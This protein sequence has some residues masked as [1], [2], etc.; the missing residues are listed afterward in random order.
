[1]N[2]ASLVSNREIGSAI[3]RRRNELSLSL[4]QLGSML[5]VSAQQ[6]QRYEN[7]IDRLNVER[8]QEIA[9]ALSVPV[10][11]FFLQGAHAAATPRDCY[12]L[13]AYFGSIQSQ[14]V[15]SIMLEWLRVLAQNEGKRSVPA[16]KLGR[17]T[18]KSPILL[19][20]DDEQVLSIVRLFLENEGYRNLH[21]I[22]DSRS[23]IPFLTEKAISLIVLDLL[24]PHMTGN[25]LLLT[26]R[27]SFP[28]IPVIIL[29]AM[30]DAESAEYCMKS[31][32]FDYLVKP[33]TPDR[34]LSA[35]D[36]ALCSICS[37]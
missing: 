17:Y 5:N 9:R 16:L 20:D 8:L 34:F 35:I 14:E 19:V 2:Q 30:G 26:L 33:V 3:R 32:V 24:M 37:E 22:R 10:C 27:E 31:G 13:F 4:E 7:G 29:T 36:K 11:F 28:Q 23:V 12:E 21:L 15:R 18:K 1:M 25:E 6:I